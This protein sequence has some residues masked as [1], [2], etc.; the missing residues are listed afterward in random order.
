VS[1][2]I[3]E[4]IFITSI[5]GYLG[6]VAGVFTLEAVSGMIEGEGI[7]QN[8][9]VDMTTAIIATLVLVVSGT[10]AGLFPAL[11]AASISPIEALREQ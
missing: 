1:L 4:A 5:A 7:F 9:E 11:R 8:P 2:I 6:L 3:M 10:L